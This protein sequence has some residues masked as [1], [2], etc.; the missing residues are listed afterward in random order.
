[1]TKRVKIKT[2]PG[3]CMVAFEC[4]EAIWLEIIDV[5]KELQGHGLGSQS[6]RLLQTYAAAVRKPVLLTP[7]PRT[8]KDGP[9][10]KR[11]YERAGFKLLPDGDMEWST[12]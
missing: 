6:L 1:M 11:F 4:D 5:K 8:D 3:V 7:V 10:L 9:A 12:R 2:P